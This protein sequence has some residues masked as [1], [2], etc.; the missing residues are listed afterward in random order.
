V[1]ERDALH[2]VAEQGRDGIE[3]VVADDDVVRRG[4]GDRDPGESR[5]PDSR[6][7]I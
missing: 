1:D 6:C 5:R 2:A 3:D 4:A 7:S